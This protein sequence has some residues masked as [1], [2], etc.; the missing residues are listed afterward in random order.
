MP[1]CTQVGANQ[2]VVNS[3][4]GI[5]GQLS[6]RNFHYYFVGSRYFQTVSIIEKRCT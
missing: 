2:D 1:S 3:D 4:I 5:E 6:W